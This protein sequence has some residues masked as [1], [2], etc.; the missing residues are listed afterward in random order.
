MLKLVK[1]ISQWFVLLDFRRDKNQTISY[2]VQ[3]FIPYWK[4][5]RCVCDQ[6]RMMLL[7]VEKKMRVKARFEPLDKCW[8]VF[9]FNENEILRI[10]IKPCDVRA[11]E[12]IIS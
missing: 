12:I 3:R 6:K 2:K 5:S 8:K 7:K 11:E 1:K 10:F 9:V 4:N